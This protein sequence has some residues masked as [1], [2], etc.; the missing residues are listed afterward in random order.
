MQ[1]GIVGIMASLAILI[2]TVKGASYAQQ[3]SWPDICVNKNSGRQSP[4]DIQDFKG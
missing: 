1:T 4:I 2:N 3:G